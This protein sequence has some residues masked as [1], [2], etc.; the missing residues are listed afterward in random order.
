MSTSLLQAIFFIGGYVTYASMSRL[1]KTNILVVLPTA[2]DKIES[3]ILTYWEYPYWTS[4]IL[5]LGFWSS[6]S[7]LYLSFFVPVISL[8]LNFKNSNHHRSRRALFDLNKKMLFK[9]NGRSYLQ[10]QLEFLYRCIFFAY[11]YLYYNTV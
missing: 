9:K 5:N 11:T 3:A 10:S 7:K 6:W 2:R 1:R 8:L 4:D